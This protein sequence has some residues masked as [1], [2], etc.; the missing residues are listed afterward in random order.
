MFIAKFKIITLDGQSGLL[1]LYHGLNMIPDMSL[2]AI[3]QL[4]NPLL[5][6]KT[7][8]FNIPNVDSLFL[9]L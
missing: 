8:F 9:R 5:Q 1:C 4:E 3:E 7:V 2:D 6:I